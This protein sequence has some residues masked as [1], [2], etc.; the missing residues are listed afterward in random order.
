VLTY[1]FE[2]DTVPTFDGA[3][4]QAS[5]AMAEGA[6]TTEWAVTGLVEN[7]TYHWRA[8]ASDGLSESDW[9][10]AS[11]TVNAANSPPGTPTIANPGD[12]AWVATSLPMLS[13]NPVVDP[14][15]DS[16]RYY[17]EIYSDEALTNLQTSFDNW[18]ENS[19]TM[20][21]PLPNNQW[22]YLRVRS[23]D[24]QGAQSAWSTVSRFYVNDN[25]I[26]DPP[27][28]S[29]IEP[30]QDIEVS[31]AE[32]TLRWDDSD[33]DSNAY[34]SIY[35][36]IDGVSQRIGVYDEDPDGVSDIFNW[37]AGKVA[38]GTYR[39]YGIIDDGNS[40]ST[41]YAPGLVTLVNRG[42]VPDV[43]GQT[44][45]EAEQTLVNAGYVLGTVQGIWSDVIPAGQV[46]DQMPR[47][48]TAVQGTVVN[49]RVSIG[50]A[51]PVPLTC[52][53]D[54]DGDIDFMDEQ[55]SY[56]VINFNGL[57]GRPAIWDIGTVTIALDPEACSLQCT[58]PNC[59]TE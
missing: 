50:S 45:S 5:P 20:Y 59:A 23:V 54:L 1:Y 6:A 44:Q 9:I 12:G 19:L 56:M 35:S 43:V 36:E 34:I 58:R 3:G 26:D 11:F 33:P 48:S 53:I 38:N 17:F 32:V 18:P 7:T 24:S 27:T 52:D 28:L 46:Q 22:Y 55:V 51:E 57:T 25:G 15:G 29:F 14:D 10:Q 41:V 47:L 8:K 42:T 21:S 13:V 49:L 30:A 2:L 40:S 4:K 37:N 39:I 16:V 31:G